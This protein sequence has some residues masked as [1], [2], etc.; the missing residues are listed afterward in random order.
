MG[1]TLLD[2]GKLD[3]RVTIVREGAPAKDSYGEL[4]PGAPVETTRWAS[5]SPAPGIERFAN[6][7]NAATALWRFVFRWSADLVRVTDNLR[8]ADGRTW[9][10][11]SVDPI[12]RNLG[13][14]VL[15]AARMEKV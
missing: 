13:L 2:A 3:Q 1:N 4:V 10:V 5:R 6:A 9:D 7:E 11:K 14:E 8:T 12:G 15:A